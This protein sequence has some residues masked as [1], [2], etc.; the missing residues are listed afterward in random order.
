MIS[1]LVVSLVTK[2]LGEFVDLAP[3]QLSVGLTSG[4]VNVGNLRFRPEALRDLNLPITVREGVLGHLRISIPWTSIWS[5][6]TRVE[7]EDIYLLAEAKQNVFDEDFDKRIQTT[8]ERFLQLRELFNHPPASEEALEHARHEEAAGATWTSRLTAAIVNN[9]QVSVKRVHIRFEEAGFAC[10]L[11]LESFAAV[12]CDEEYV[13]RMVGSSGGVVRKL[14]SLENLASYWDSGGAPLRYDSAEDFCGKMKALIGRPEDATHQYLLRPMSGTLK[15]AIHQYEQPKLRLQATFQEVHIS[16]HETQFQDVLSL[17]ERF[18]MEARGA[19]YRRLRPSRPGAT[20]RQMWHYVVGA[21]RQDLAV[22]RSVWSWPWIWAMMNDRRD[23]VHLWCQSKVMGGIDRMSILDSDKL[24][25]LEFRMEYDSIVQ[26]RQLG[27]LLY[28]RKLALAEQAMQQAQAEG[29]WLGRVVWGTPQAEKQRVLEEDTPVTGTLLQDLTR[30]LLTRQHAAAARDGSD[31]RLDGT[32][33]DFVLEKGVVS[34]HGFEKATREQSDLV[35]AEFE[36]VAAH[37]HLGRGKSFRFDMT[38]VSVAEFVSVPNRK[39]LAVARRDST[40]VAEKV[41]LSVSLDLNPP[42]KPDIDVVVRLEA[43]PVDV[44]LSM[45][46]IERMAKFFTS[47]QSMMLDELLAQAQ[48]SV[49]SLQREVVNQIRGIASGDQLTRVEVSIDVEA[50]NVVIPANFVNP[51]CAR[52]VAVLGTIRVT[53]VPPDLAKIVNQAAGGK[54]HV[55]MDYFYQQA[56]SVAISN[57]HL[58]VCNQ[59]DWRSAEKLLPRSKVLDDFGLDMTVSLLTFPT[60]CLPKLK[61]NAKLSPLQ[62]N[63]CA[64]SILGLMRVAETF[65]PN[66][67]DSPQDQLAKARQRPQMSEQ[68]TAFFDTGSPQSEEV[69]PAELEN[70]VFDRSQF[71]FSRNSKIV[72]VAFSMEKIEVLVFKRLSSLRGLNQSMNRGETKDILALQCQDVALQITQRR[73]DVLIKMHVRR[74]GVADKLL[75]NNSW[76]LDGMRVPEDEVLLHLTFTGIPRNSPL[77]AGVDQEIKVKLS[78]VGFSFNRETVLYVLDTIETLNAAMIQLPKVQ[79]VAAEGAEVSVPEVQPLFVSSAV[80][81]VG[82]VFVNDTTTNL[83]VKVILG[84]VTAQLCRDHDAFAVLEARSSEVTADI[85]CNGTL[86]VDS[87]FGWFELRAPSSSS[88]WPKIAYTKRSSTETAVFS[89][90]TFLPHVE[91][92]RGIDARLQLQMSTVKLVYRTVFVEE[93]VAYFHEMENMRSYLFSAAEAAVETT[94]KSSLKFALDV[95]INNPYIKLP[96]SSSSEEYL[97]LDLGKTTVMTSF[98][99][100]MQKFSLG[101]NEIGVCRCLASKPEEEIDVLK[102]FD[103]ALLVQIAP[104]PAQ[105][106]VSA[107]VSPVELVLDSVIVDSCLGI[108]EGNLS[109]GDVVSLP[110]PVQDMSVP[111]LGADQRSVHQSSSAK[112]GFPAMELTVRIEE[113][114]LTVAEVASFHVRKMFGSISASGNVSLS[115]EAVIMSDR[116][117]DRS[118][119]FDQVISKRENP[120]TKG[121]FR[122]VMADPVLRCE[123]DADGFVSVVVN[124]LRIVVIWGCLMKLYL[125]QASFL[126]RFLKALAGQTKLPELDTGVTVAAVTQGGSESGSAVAAAVVNITLKGFEAF[127]LEDIRSAR[128]RAL[129]LGVSSTAMLKMRGSATDV[130]LEL[131]D[132]SVNKVFSMESGVFASIL[133]P[134]RLGLSYN[135]VVNRL[136]RIEAVCAPVDIV[137][138]HGDYVLCVALYTEAIRFVDPAMLEAQ[139]AAAKMKGDAAVQLG[140]L[141]LEPPRQHREV[142]ALY[143]L[144]EAEPLSLR[145][146]GS[147]FLS[148]GSEKGTGSLLCLSATGARQTW[149]LDGGKI[150]SGENPE[151]G[152]VYIEEIGT[153]T[154]TR[155]KKTDLTEW[156][157]RA[158]EGIFRLASNPRMVLTAV[159]DWVE[160]RELEQDPSNQVWAFGSHVES[161]PAAKADVSTSSVMGKSW[162]VAQ[163]CNVVM[164][165]VKVRFVDDT[166]RGQIEPLLSLEFQ[167]LNAFVSSWSEDMSIV[168]DIQMM[169]DHFDSRLQNWEPMIRGMNEARAREG[170]WKCQIVALNNR[171]VV[172]ADVVAKRVL[173]F[174]VT[175]SM[176]ASFRRLTLIW[177]GTNEQL[178]RL[179]SR[180]ISHLPSSSALRELLVKPDPKSNEQVYRPYIVCNKTGASIRWYIG[181]DAPKELSSEAGKNVAFWAPEGRQALMERA[182]LSVY[183]ENEVSPSLKQLPIDGARLLCFSLGKRTVVYEIKYEMGSRVLEIRSNMQFSSELQSHPVPIIC[184]NVV[185]GTLEPLGSLAVPLQ[186]SSGCITLGEGRAEMIDQ[187]SLRSGA[188]VA[189]NGVLKRTQKVTGG[190]G[191]VYTVTATGTPDLMAEHV[192]SWEIGVGAPFRVRNL[193]LVDLFLRLRNAKKELLQDD[194]RVIPGDTQE[195]LFTAESIS[196]RYSDHE[197]SPFSPV[198]SVLGFVFHS[199]GE[200]KVENVIDGVAPKEPDGTSQILTFWTPFWIVNNTMHKV[201]VQ[202]IPLLPFLPG[203]E[204]VMY[205]GE[206]LHLSLGGVKAKTN[207]RLA[208][209]PSTGVIAI[210][211]VD[212]GVRVFAAPSQFWRT[213]VLQLDDR[214]HIA[215]MCDRRICVGQKKTAQQIHIEPNEQKV[216]QWHDAAAPRSIRVK[217]GEDKWLW[218]GAFEIKEVSLFEVVVA[219]DSG[220]RA[221]LMVQTTTDAPVTAIIFRPSLPNFSIYRIVNNTRAPILVQQAGVDTDRGEWLNPKEKVPFAWSEPSQQNPLAVLS[222]PTAVLRNMN[223][224]KLTETAGNLPAFSLDSVETWRTFSC[225]FEGAARPVP[226]EMKVYFSGPTKIFEVSE[227]TSVSHGISVNRGPSRMVV[228]ANNTVKLTALMQLRGI[229]VALI[230]SRPRE[231]L[232]MQLGNVRM[233]FVDGDKESVLELDIGRVQVDN[234]LYNPLFP[235][236]FWPLQPSGTAFFHFG[237]NQAKE[238]DGITF[239]N[240]IEV[241]VQEGE[242]RVDEGLATHVMAALSDIFAV[243]TQDSI[244]L[245]AIA[246]PVPDYRKTAVSTADMV[247][248]RT[249][250]IG[251]VRMLVSYSSCPWGKVPL[252]GEHGAQV[253]GFLAF[254]NEVNGVFI[255]LGMLSLENAYHSRQALAWLLV[256]HYQWQLVRGFFSLLGAFP[257][258]GAP[259]ELFR[260]ITT[261]AKSVLALPGQGVARSPA[262]F[263]DRVTHTVSA[264][265]QA[266]VVPTMKEMTK[267]TTAMSSVVTNAIFDDDYKKKRQ[268]LS[269]RHARGGLEGL[270]FA[271]RDL[272]GGLAN[273]LTSVVSNPVQGAA[274]D[275]IRG[276]GKGVLSGLVGAVLKPVVGVIDAVGQIGY[277]VQNGPRRGR[278]RLRRPRA[279]DQTACVLPYDEQKAAA[280]E[281]LQTLDN[282]LHAMSIAVFLYPDFGCLERSAKGK[283]TERRNHALISNKAVFLVVGCDVTDMSMGWRV[284]LTDIKVVLVDGTSVKLVSKQRQEVHELKMATKPEAILV[285]RKIMRAQGMENERALENIFTPARLG[286]ST[287]RLVER[288]EGGDSAAAAHPKRLLLGDKGKEEMLS[289][290][291]G[292]DEV[293]KNE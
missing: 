164:H 64:E 267:V 80:S 173:T 272:V 37:M 212:F 117:P 168:V 151:M 210:D 16:V 147:R 234:M 282:S 17:G 55:S 216:F 47:A 262:D 150:V 160:L 194:L 43:R 50:P 163:S 177:T 23:Y 133:S 226:L 219:K 105:M 239:F 198:K 63:V 248:A 200:I 263:G 130:E 205:S 25:E 33:A 203:K 290:C 171:G 184:G 223:G 142:S 237:V 24:R 42:S 217:I 82:A 155:A 189:Q 286:P 261:G 241:I 192:V 245:S 170:T 57:I 136:E 233:T 111:A 271:G 243:E 132:F 118:P 137:F 114:S 76:M 256:Q 14:C 96:R 7:L 204:P 77:F 65:S 285:Y 109:E 35:Q 48:E 259:Q 280:Q 249:L 257:I 6:P 188:V 106:A 149:L 78:D 140:K 8:K 10:G 61:L 264:M 54:M 107:L 100:E 152:I 31:A 15:A 284:S 18:S 270:K 134:W 218:S 224:E 125:F 38:S 88:T 4:E 176:I 59:E 68:L 145:S 166:V 230:D 260:G 169:A 255:D 131:N 228:N 186:L 156:T 56:F 291:V 283:V 58:L 126:D 154:V 159:G 86:S 101:I 273:G 201:A 185:V 236:V 277:G 208:S 122:A 269:K 20:P 276:F 85:R 41:L 120:K 175:R 220:V 238:Q 128:S 229:S 278:A 71:D 274:S 266:L 19:P 165:N 21:V 5:N 244:D 94:A 222:F 247:Y 75:G 99:H 215:N 121:S 172:R 84:S 2:Y 69:F 213:K 143:M 49:A 102:K 66:P 158:D 182:T 281:A 29:G 115:L 187:E 123:M 135:S 211:A 240:G 129:V 127:V 73:S 36:A 103:I 207:I 74:L 1:G 167:R 190:G 22:R 26:F 179:A 12:S 209:A 191:L 104:A 52:A 89:L 141:I 183:L 253:E 30:E 252:P 60:R 45:P 292:S 144:L 199:G 139:A 214:L 62:G 178:Q 81:S 254:L 231:V 87:N 53:S 181:Y 288:L 93:A 28:E 44:L 40:P 110:H 79:D 116:R 32:T 39:T 27:E 289:V 206:D 275:G 196:V 197:W 265:N 83:L 138:S 51:T 195:F 235:I 258:L 242:V 3:D 13:A 108:L 95:T 153:V 225:E 174:N 279:F 232:H 67:V 287:M 250:Y 162:F 251:P 72:D 193:L 124:P 246:V 202:E 227:A 161:Q 113:V 9:V 34:L 268:V 293:N 90:E 119:F 91:G 97:R 221:R 148:E 146:D 11:S 157:F 98:Q 112:S 46:F 92:Y 180:E 70:F